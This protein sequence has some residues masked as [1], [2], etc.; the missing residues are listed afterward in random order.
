[1][2]PW[3]FAHGHRLYTEVWF[4][5]P[6]GM[7]VGLGAAFR[8][9]GTSLATARLTVLALSL[10]GVLGV[11]L[12]ARRLGG[13]SAGL[14]AALALL[15]APHFFWLVRSINPDT[16]SMAL[17]VLALAA[18]W[19]YRDGGARALVPLAGAL[20][21]LGI[22]IKLNPLL[23]LAPAFVLL[24]TRAWR[25]RTSAKR[26]VAWLTRLLADGVLFL[27]PILALVASWALVAPPRAVLAGVFGTLSRARGAFPDRSGEY[28]LWL[29]RDNLLGENLALVALGLLGLAWLARRPERRADAAALALWLAATGHALITQRP[30]WPKHHWSLLL[31]PLAILS[32]LGLGALLELGRAALRRRRAGGG[33]DAEEMPTGRSRAWWSRARRSYA[34]T[35]AALAA[36]AIA[37]YALPATAARLA[38]TASP[39]QFSAIVAGAEWVRE[40]V[41]PDRAIVTDAGQLAFLAGRAMPPSM[42]T[43]SSKR[44]RIGDLDDATIIRAAADPRSAAVLLWNDHL[45]DFKAFL[46]WL[47][48]HYIFAT[49]VGEDRAIWRRFEPDRIEH[50]QNARLD[51]LADLEG[52][53]LS[54][55]QLR[56]GET[57]TATLYWRAR[58][59][60][61]A[62]RRTFVHLVDATGQ[63]R[64]QGDGEPGTGRQPAPAWRAKEIVVDPRPITLPPDLSPGDYRLRIGLYDPAT[65]SR[66]PAFKPEGAR[67][68][69]DAVELEGL[70]TVRP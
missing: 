45:T 5:Q 21:G 36:L 70:V 25:A 32:G 59:P 34:W 51:D 56:A 39:R 1:M 52:Y 8:L 6:P 29:L 47:P 23:L 40:N 64:A 55:T 7:A 30:M 14:G 44:I 11:A 4:D 35:V 13:R 16:P 2:V 57:L 62:E 61:P 46:D 54:S 67:W 58:G 33:V 3:A 12:I 60:A 68:A 50:P 17:G 53:A 69:E 10:L 15:L 24:A 38:E 19:R 49:M 41:P 31:W 27:L 9:L 28:A 26:G 48:T 65:G 18:L 20:L 43:I 66:V 42:V 37:L 22:S 63:T